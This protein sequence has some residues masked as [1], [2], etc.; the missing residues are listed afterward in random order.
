MGKTLTFFITTICLLSCATSDEQL[1]KDFY[2]KRPDG[3]IEYDKSS[4]DNSITIKANPASTYYLDEIDNPTAIPMIGFETSTNIYPKVRVIVT[5][6]GTLAMKKLVVKHDNKL[7]TLN[8]SR[9]ADIK[10]KISGNYVSNISKQ[11]FLTNMST[12]KKIFQKPEK[13]YLR[14]YNS[15]GDYIE[16]SFKKTH[17]HDKSMKSFY[18]KN[19]LKNFENKLPTSDMALERFLA[20]IEKNKL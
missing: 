10:T 9:T 4:F 14:I 2:A 11:I 16:S 5:L 20:E 15:K 18:Q 8:A 12:I 17:D 13:S 7:V 6:H 3:K 1:M 19:G